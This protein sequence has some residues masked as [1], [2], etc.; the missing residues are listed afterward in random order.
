MSHRTVDSALQHYV[1]SNHLYEVFEGYIH[2]SQYATNSST[3]G[4]RSAPV[5]IWCTET[6]SDCAN[7]T[8]L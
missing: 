2:R 6:R 7:R 5:T 8:T 1:S 4:P 3:G